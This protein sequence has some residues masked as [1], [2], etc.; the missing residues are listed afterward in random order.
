MGQ[1]VGTLGTAKTIR[2]PR[3]LVKASLVA[4]A[5][6]GI[7]G[8]CSASQSAG[9]S[10]GPAT[11]EAGPATTD[12]GS[13]P[14][15]GSGPPPTT[16]ALPFTDPN[17]ACEGALNAYINRKLAYEPSR[18]M[19]I[20]QPTTVSVELGAGSL[21]PLTDISPENTT[22][23]P[24]KSTCEVQAQLIGAA[25]D[26][27]P[28]GW[29]Q[30]S[31]L[32]VPVVTWVWQVTPKD[33]GRNLDLELE[34]Q[35][36]FQVSGNPPVPGGP[37]PFDAKITVNAAHQT[38]VQQANNAANSSLGAGVLAGILSPSILALVGGIVA[39]WKRHRI[40]AWWRRRRNSKQLL[41]AEPLTAAEPEGDGDIPDRGR[42]APA[43]IEQ[44]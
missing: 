20:G 44:D 1:N 32:T 42:P 40:R 4:I 5:L 37:P 22:V 39:F 23:V 14:T 27:S 13:P 9:S 10:G 38:F 24:L 15:E 8:A 6:S 25:F 26:I 41:T 33:A 17:A 36:L 35:S 16:P 18:V 3:N 2:R 11:T 34:V 12:G 43:H 29:Q 7:A 19:E 31:F 21:P 28:T 30:A